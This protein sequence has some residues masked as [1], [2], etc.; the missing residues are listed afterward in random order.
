MIQ[1]LL[2]ESQGAPSGFR[3]LQ[4]DSGTFEGILGEFLGLLGISWTFDGLLNF[5]FRFG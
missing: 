4:G 2:K 1:G 3:Q 5:I